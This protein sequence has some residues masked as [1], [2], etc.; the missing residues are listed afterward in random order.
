M[1]TLEHQRAGS[2]FVTVE[3]AAG[4]ARYLRIID[5]GFAVQHDG[6]SPSGQGDVVALPL[7]RLGG[8]VDGGPEK[9]VEAAHAQ[10]VG[11]LAEVVINLHLVSATQVNAAVALL[12]NV[13]FEVQLEVGEFLFADDV[14][15]G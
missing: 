9:T 4:D 11:R 12:D 7:A 8:G 6:D 10:A 1:I 15:A 3:R 5:D 2:A 13:E 14:D